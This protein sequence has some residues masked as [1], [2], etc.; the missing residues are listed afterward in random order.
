MKFLNFLLT[1]LFE[2]EINKNCPHTNINGGLIMDKKQN[3]DQME[4]N[5]SQHEKKGGQQK[6]PSST[7]KNPSHKQQ[8]R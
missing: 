7:E 4:K 2:C 8:G 3:H 5:P 6:S 1:V